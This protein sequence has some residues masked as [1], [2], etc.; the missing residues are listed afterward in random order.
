MLVERPLAFQVRTARNYTN[1]ILS[2]G[3]K[4]MIAGTIDYMAAIETLPQG[5]SLVLPNISWEEYEHF[6]SEY[7][8][9][10]GLL[11][12]Y[13]QGTLTIMST[14]PEHEEYKDTFLR[15]ISALAEELDIDLESR[16]SATFRKKIKARGVEPDTCF[17][18]QNAHC[19]IGQRTIDLN[20]D[21]PPDVAVEIDNTADSTKK[22]S[23][24]ASLEVPELWLYN[25]TQVRFYKLED[26]VYY[27]IENSIAFPLLSSDMLTNFIE[28]SKTEGQTA[29]LKAF[30][31]WVR[32]RVEH[33]S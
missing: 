16:G 18:V 7:P 26:G 9:R 32:E 28:Q 23:I 4:T 12:W 17:Y 30:R 22:F 27:E 1:D 6:L 29:T 8:E 31:K 14:T 11:V 24:Y 13:D 3:E 19:L 21:P 5:A 10:P 15:L 20:V 25:L 33:E 2:S